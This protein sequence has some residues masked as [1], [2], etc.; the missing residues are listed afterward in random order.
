MNEIKDHRWIHLTETD[1]F[2]R[3]SAIIRIMPSKHGDA[4][5]LFLEDGKTHMVF[6]TTTEDFF[7]A[8][9]VDRFDPNSDLIN[10]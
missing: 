2:I 5:V 10:D 6:N 3:K 1:V 8:F 7:D 4:V 9:L